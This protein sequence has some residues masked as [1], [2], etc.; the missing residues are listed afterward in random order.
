M[1]P[2]DPNAPKPWTA[3]LRR[4]YPVVLKRDQMLGITVSPSG[5]VESVEEQMPPCV[6]YGRIPA[7]TRAQEKQLRER[8][9]HEL[10]RRR[11]L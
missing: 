5:V 10:E 3:Y 4:V 11:F 8:E 7:P 2:E 9:W 1:F 6:N